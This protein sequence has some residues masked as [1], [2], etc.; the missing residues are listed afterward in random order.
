LLDRLKLSADPAIAK[1]AEENAARL[2][3]WQ[4][5]P[6][7]QLAEQNSESLTAP[8][9]RRKPGATDPELDRLEAAQSGTDTE[10]TPAKG[11]VKFVRAVL[12]AADCPA[13]GNAVLQLAIG[14]KRVKVRAPN[15]KKILVIGADEF[16]C[17]WKNKR[18]AINYRE[19]TPTEGDLISIEVTTP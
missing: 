3:E 10:P 17:G 9:W 7:T 1:A 5:H 12:V 2:K 8:Q 11:P 16:Q 19:R 4:A 13:A 6:L 15:A 14:P 18:V